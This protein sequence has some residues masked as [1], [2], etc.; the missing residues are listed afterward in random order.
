[1][2][3]RNI[4]IT[5]LVLIL[6][7]SCSQDLEYKQ[8]GALTIN[9]NLQSKTLEP[10]QDE[11][12]I[13]SYTIKLKPANSENVTSY[14]AQGTSY[15]IYNL[16]AGEYKVWVEGVNEKGTTIL[17]SDTQTITITNKQTTTAVFDV[18]NI[19][20]GLGTFSFSVIIPK[21][22]D[23][24]ESVCFLIFTSPSA[25]NEYSPT[26]TRTFT[27]ENASD[28]LEYKSFD[29]SLTLPAGSYYLE[30]YMY[31]EDDLQVGYTYLDSFFIYK[32]ATT[33]SSVTWDSEF[34][35]KVVAPVAGIIETDQ[36]YIKITCSNPIATI[37]YTTDGTSPDTSSTKYLN[38]IPLTE[39]IELRA[40][41]TVE[42]LRSSNVVSL[43]YFFTVED[44]VFSIVTNSVVDYD[45]LEIT[46]PTA[47]AT[48]IYTLD[49]SEPSKDNGKVYK[50]PV[51]I[52]KTCLVKAIAIKD[53][54]NN[55]AVVSAQ[56]YDINTSSDSKYFSIT[57]QGA[58]SANRDYDGTLPSILII[59]SELNGI[60][61]TEIAKNAFKNIKDITYVAIPDT[62]TV[63]GD[64]A[65]Y[66]C[67]NIE[68]IDLSVYLTSIGSS[69]FS[70][71]TEAQR[72][73]DYSG[74]IKAGVL[75]NC[76]AKLYVTIK[77]GTQI[78][79]GYTGMENLYGVYMSNN[80]TTIAENAFS[81][82]VNLEDFTLPEYVTYIGSLA[83]NEC[84]KIKSI[85]L[86]A[87]LKLEKFATDAFRGWTNEQSIIDTGG[88][89]LNGSFSE[90]NA[91]VYTT[92]PSTYTTITTLMFKDRSD[93]YGVEIPSSITTIEA[94]AFEG[95]SIEKLVIPKTVETL[96]VEVFKDWTPEQKIE[97]VYGG[98][99]APSLLTEEATAFTNCYA[100][101]TVSIDPSVT[102]I[103]ANAFSGMINLFAIDI[104]SSVTKIGDL[105]F[106][107]TSLATVTLGENVK[108]IGDYCFA[109]CTELKEVNLASG[110]TS[111]GSYAF[112]GCNSLQS[113]TL[114]DTVTSIGD[115]AF[116]SCA[117]LQTVN[118]GTGVTTIPKQAFDG[119]PKLSS[120]IAPNCKGSMT[121]TV[122][123]PLE[124][125]IVHDV[126]IK[127]TPAYASTS[128]YETKIS[129]AE[130][131][132]NGDWRVFTY[133]VDDM[134]GLYYNVEIVLYDYQDVQVGEKTFTDCSVT[135]GNNCPVDCQFA[136]S[137]L[138]ERNL[139]ATT[140]TP[141]G[142]TYLDGAEIV[143]ANTDD[144]SIRYTFDGSTPTESNGTIYSEPIV[145]HNL[146]NVKAVAYKEGYAFAFASTNYSAI[147]VQALTISLDPSLSYHPSIYLNLSTATE[148]ATI[149]YKIGSS[150]YA[151]YESPIEISN[152]S[153]VYAYATKAGFT[154]SSTVSATYTV[155]HTWN[156][157]E[158]TTTPTC[159]KEGVRT[160]TCTICNETKTETISANGHSYV[161]Y[162]CTICGCGTAGGYVF[163]DCDADNDSGNADGLI[164]TECGWRYLEAAPTALSYT[165]SSG[166]TI[167]Y[168]RFGYYR[169][170][171]SGSN[172]TVGTKTTIGT[173][174]ANTEALVKAMGE[175][176]Y[177]SSSGTTKGIYAAKACADYSITVDGVVY[178]DW[179]LPSK[180][181]L[182]L[183]YDNLKA[184]GLGSFA[185]DYY[186][187]WSSSEYSCDN[188]WDQYFDYGNQ[189]GS[190]RSCNGYVHPV[191]AF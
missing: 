76:N 137:D 17:Y 106:V 89:A 160:Y 167:W 176:A 164:S 69:A 20:E 3:K 25:Y 135:A 48:I 132:I 172:L 12:Q 162:S 146:K 107:A 157:G 190:S 123:V 27:P 94:N 116:A 5:I 14:S 49:G 63:I 177:R 36:K 2:S 29:L 84:T 114:P 56:Y 119:S 82:S 10:A 92:I 53:N 187:Y 112:S 121:V 156:A 152:T 46:T 165:N 178:D 37:Y 85:T 6:F 175:T 24:V 80:I 33:A 21:N 22:A 98:Y 110:L 75:V 140:I 50:G 74:L 41:A 126:A 136:L 161:D 77:A 31:N 13:A 72:I 102:E 45:E 150:S 122:K 182:D 103:K 91:K 86:P 39:S 183:M 11:S 163:Y 166:T 174:K 60:E 180:N 57:T 105:A 7:A 118:L 145:L 99:T 159:D 139:S 64:G 23:F 181:E 154:N 168:Y 158:V 71:W 104:P 189:S 34:L 124:Q 73:N 35:P 79:S 54:F 133:T 83:F 47:G 155:E 100:M 66:G 127:I 65:F 173:G 117:N 169:T 131:T 44:P 90:S 147:K 1:M 52:S 115:E 8:Y 141:T 97:I 191:R 26:A 55:S 18:D 149:Y 62:V 95:T 151:K 179:F 16:E 87:I 28:D 153:T 32:N 171:S 58:I 96:G 188:A 88:L 128:G 129:R 93:I 143:I 40:I 148:G 9:T 144:V 67:T 51:V 125:L 19:S 138:T 108:S 59:P 68:S 81:G 38:P 184:K 142:S 186:G 185:S 43:D 113:I 120:I 4:F 15:T 170:S 109:Y 78:V 134:L 101:F 30:A 70:G 130:Q 111:V 42:G 61:V